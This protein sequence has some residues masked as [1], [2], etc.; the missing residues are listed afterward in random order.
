MAREPIEKNI[1]E[2]KF[3]FYQLPPRKSLNLMLRMLQILG[4]PL[5]GGFAKSNRENLLDSD[6][7]LGKI[8]T[9]L[10]ERINIGE[11]EFIINEL[12][13]QVICEGQG[14]VLKNFDSIFAGRLPLLFKVVYEM[15]N[16]EYSAF[17]V[18]KSA[19]QSFLRKADTAPKK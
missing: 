10:C 14:E 4:S 8:V 11:V 1:D 9:A 5:G 16:I 15:L 13:S 19:F 3:I 6:I 7:D 2:F 18:G 17:F 12:I